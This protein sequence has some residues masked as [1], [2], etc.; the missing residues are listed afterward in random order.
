MRAKLILLSAATLLLGAEAAR[1]AP[2]AVQTYIAGVSARADARLADVGA[3]VP[4]GVKVRAVVSGDRLQ[5]V[6]VAEGTGDLAADRAVEQALRR[7]KV[8]TAPPELSGREVVLTLGVP[9][10]VQARTR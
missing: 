6:R 7:L 3:A 4:A 1:A 10:I 8:E 9:P 2:A 5:S